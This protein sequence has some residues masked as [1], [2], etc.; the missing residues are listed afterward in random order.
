MLSE[1]ESRRVGSECEELTD[2]LDE[3]EAFAARVYVEQAIR[4]GECEE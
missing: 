4:G 1:V 3:T 2:C